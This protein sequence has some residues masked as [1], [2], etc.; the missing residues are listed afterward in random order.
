MGKII[1][2]PVT[3]NAGGYE[4]RTAESKHLGDKTAGA[5]ASMPANAFEQ[6]SAQEQGTH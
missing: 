4:T 6:R 3:P 5:N 2:A 1:N